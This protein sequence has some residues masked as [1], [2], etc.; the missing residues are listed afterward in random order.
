MLSPLTD[1]HLAASD[2]GIDVAW[3]AVLGAALPAQPPCVVLH[4]HK[5]M[6]LNTQSIERYM[7]P[8][9]QKQERNCA[10]TCGALQRLLAPR[11]LWKNYSHDNG[12]CWQMTPTGLA[13]SGWYAIDEVGM[14]RARLLTGPGAGRPLFRPLP[15]AGAASVA[16]AASAAGAAGADG[17][18]SAIGGSGGSAEADGEPALG[19][20]WLGATSTFSRNSQL[21]TCLA[22]LRKLCNAHPALRVVVNYHDGG[23]PA[24]PKP[25]AA[26]ATRAAHGVG[27]RTR[28]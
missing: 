4:G 24:S 20:R 26:A 21:D 27:L 8:Q 2:F 3:C 5:A 16:G 13:R 28:Y 23:L 9:V 11:G 1:T 25:G 19:I 14:V 15:E 22:Q 17:N 10:G 18:G 12:A 7:S 6:H